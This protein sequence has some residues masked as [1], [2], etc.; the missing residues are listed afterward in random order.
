VRLVQFKDLPV[1]PWR[2]GGGV[3]REVA[4]FRGPDDGEFL[5]RLSIATVN[6]D[7]PFS[8]FEGIDRTIA[9]LAGRGIALQMPDR[10]V[11]V[12]GDTGPFSFAG[13]TPVHAVVLEGETTDLNA[14]TRRGH[15]IHTMRRLQPNA[16]TAIKGAANE[17]ILVFGGRT[18]VE[19]PDESVEAG[20]FDALAEIA[21]GE[22]ILIHPDAGAPTYL[23][24]FSATS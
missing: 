12:T 16:R 10:T 11:R 3:T 21:P 19:G 23:I 1:V 2:N 7:G 14:M 5:W 22:E 9:V 4:A 17:T 15:F 13:E 6:A 18:I 8:A 24:E 20:A